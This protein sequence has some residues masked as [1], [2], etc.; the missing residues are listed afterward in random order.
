MIITHAPLRLSFLG[1]GTDF[2]DFYRQYV[3]AVLTT[4]ID[5]YVRVVVHDSFDNDIHLHYSS[6]ERVKSIGEIKHGLI[7]ESMKVAGETVGIEIHTIGQVPGEGTGLGSSSTTTVALL[8]A[9]S[10]HR[11]QLPTCEWLAHKAC[12]IEINK[13][14]KPIGR[15]DQYIAS[16][17]GM[18]FITFNNRGIKVTSVNIRDKDR[19]D[20]N[21]LMFYTGITRQ[22]DTILTD[23]RANIPAKTDVLCAMAILAQKGKCAVELGEFDEFGLMLNTNWELKKQ[24]SSRISAPDID[25]MYAEVVRAGAL[26]GKIAGAGAGGFLV[27][28]CRNGQQDSVRSALHGLREFRFR[29][30]PSGSKVIYSD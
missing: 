27:V 6:L 20:D 19:L 1:G 21:I 3:G 8:H 5:K 25:D 4:A 10:L 7:R 17:G 29:F 14:G 18:R 30:E 2:E 26:G 12:E 13:L 15:Q 11:H 16:Y 9:L 24:L 28:Y 23:Q 22:S